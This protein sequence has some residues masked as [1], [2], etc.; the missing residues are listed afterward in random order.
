MIR[1]LARFLVA[2]FFV[3]VGVRHFTD[4][5]A[6][7]GIM[8]P[9]LPWHLELVYISGVFEIL[10]GIGLLI[11][12]TRRQ[13]GFGLLLLLLAVFPAN[14]H[15]LVNE[16]YFADMPKERWL[17]WARLPLQL[18]FAV[19]VLWVAELGSQAPSQELPNQA[20]TSP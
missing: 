12:A 5:Q 14:I 20:G 3:S 19:A 9:Y 2:L 11:P 1:T 15:M 6:F 7:V 17:L 18:V 10:G 13:A 16:V 8:P 4:A